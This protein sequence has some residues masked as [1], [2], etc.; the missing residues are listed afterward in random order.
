MLLKLQKTSAQFKVQVSSLQS[1]NKA[2]LTLQEPDFNGYTDDQDDMVDACPAPNCVDNVYDMMSPVPATS[3]D[4]VR[5]LVGKFNNCSDFIFV[6][7][8]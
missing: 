1:E 6:V 5:N 2:T 7:M 3:Y 8:F 4:K